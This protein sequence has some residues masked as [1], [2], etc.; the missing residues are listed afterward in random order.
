MK[1]NY[2]RKINLILAFLLCNAA[3]YSKLDAQSTASYSGLSLEY[4]TLQHNLCKGWNTWDTRSV[5]THV[6]LPAYL[7]I[8]LEFEDILTHK[9]IS[10]PF[11]IGEDKERLIKISPGAHAYDGSF[12]SLEFTWNDATI[13]IRSAHA[14]NDNIILLESLNEEAKKRIRVVARVK[15]MWDMCGEVN[16][17]GE[18][19]ETTRGSDFNVI[20]M[21]GGPGE[22]TKQ[23]LR[24]SM[25]EE[26][27]AISTGKKRNIK[28]IRD[29]VN[30]A[31]KKHERYSDK[32]GKEKESYKAMQAVQ[33][34]NVVYDPWNRRAIV[35]VTR[36]W[37]VARGGWVLFLW[38]TYFSASCLALDN[39]ELAYSNAINVTKGITPAG[40]VP[41][42]RGQ[43]SENDYDRSQPPVG[44]TCVLQIY[45]RWK[46]KWFLEEVFNE[47]LAWN[48]WWNEDRQRDGYLCWGSSNVP[49]N[50]NNL[51]SRV[52]VGNG[53]N[54]QDAK[55]ESGLDNSP[56]YL[57]AEFDYQHKGRIGLLLLG[58]VGLMGLYVADCNALIEIAKEIG[59]EDVIA[60]L[61]Q[62]AEKYAIKL[63]RMYSEKDGI[64]LIMILP[65]N[66]HHGVFLQHCF[67]L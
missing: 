5:V 57:D 23:E 58:D 53:G 19:I 61:Q 42:G 28:E 66:N 50:W 52:N 1:N 8:E 38:D 12:S 26:F 45:K 62:R 2:I 41:N 15:Y 16:L 13:R 64:F 14:G 36:S 40:F 30:Q 9:R 39:K 63:K 24:R 29:I 56:M 17:V 33:A 22:N 51:P 49:E 27:V 60:E 48:R 35:P 21:I 20:Y 11:F 65:K 46:D 37:N 32:F 31:E 6:L 10:S 55:F 4:K 43:I 25:S 47:L 3:L 7:G 18:H 34:W 67:I 44:S 59:R 54:R